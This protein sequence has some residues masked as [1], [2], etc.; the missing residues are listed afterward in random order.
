MKDI[1]W[2]NLPWSHHPRFEYHEGRDGVSKHHWT[3]R[4]IARVTNRTATAE[5]Y[6]KI[7]QAPAEISNASVQSHGT[8][9]SLSTTVPWRVWVRKTMGCGTA[10]TFLALVAC[11]AVLV[12]TVSLDLGKNV[13]P[14]FHFLCKKV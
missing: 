8:L 10:V 4:P 7:H 1:F 9:N 6:I 14:K 12:D 11:V 5:T 3:V 2:E 13:H